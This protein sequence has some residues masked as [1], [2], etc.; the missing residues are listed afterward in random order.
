M[1]AK[2]VSMIPLTLFQVITQLTPFVSG[3]LAFLWLGEKL[4]AFQIGAMVVCFV[5]IAIVAFSNDA[6]EESDGVT[7]SKSEFT[8]Y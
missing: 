4:A 8:E 6:E 7:D 5:G 1:V 3:L 2:T